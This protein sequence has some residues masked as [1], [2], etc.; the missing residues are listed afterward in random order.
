MDGTTWRITLRDGVTFH[1]GKALDAQAVIDSWNYTI[2][3]NP[4]LNDLLFIDSMSADGLV[5]TVTTTKEVP[6]FNRRPV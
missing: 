2:E 4:R 6:A 3:R 5:L 1:N